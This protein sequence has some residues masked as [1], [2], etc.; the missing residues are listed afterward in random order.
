MNG[1]DVRHHPV[2]QRRVPRHQP[3]LHSGAQRH[4][5]VGVHGRDRQAVEQLCRHAPDHRH[6]G[7]A[8]RHDKML[9]LA[10]RQTGVADRPFD[11]RAQPPQ[12]RLRPRL[13]TFPRHRPDKLLS[14]VHDPH[15]VLVPRGQGP[16]GDLSGMAQVAPHGEVVTQ[17]RQPCRG[18]DRFHEARHQDSGEVVAA[19][20]VVARGGLDLHH[21]LEHLEDRHV[22]RAAA[23]VEHQ[24][25]FL[26]PAMVEPVGHRRRG[27]FV[28]QAAHAQPGQLPRR[29][30]RL[31]LSVAEIG[32][33]GDHGLAHRLAEEALGILPQGAQHQGGQLLGAERPSGKLE[34]MVGPHRALEGGG[35]AVRPGGQSVPRRLTHQR[36]A[37]LGDADAG[38]REHRAQRVRD[39]LRRAAAEDRRQAVRR[40]QIDA[41]DHAGQL[42]GIP[43][44]CSSRV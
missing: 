1:A 12:Q 17:G 38:R 30:G 6:A 26:C 41:D 39:Q 7:G 9:D 34:D 13:E 42:T 32:G 15:R 28:E 3:G 24:D 25:A 8:A 31:A 37:I 20:T 23:Q 22:E 29:L 5:L 2:G 18:A 27:R 36:G 35:A 40:A 19:Q 4:H 16:L 10:R 21:P 44:A 11:G 33:D 43:P 14:L